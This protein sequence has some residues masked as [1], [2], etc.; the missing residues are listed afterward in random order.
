MKGVGKTP[1]KTQLDPTSGPQATNGAKKTAASSKGAQKDQ[2]GAGAVRAGG[3]AASAP[4]PAGD[5]VA[6]EAARFAEVAKIPAR[7]APPSGAQAALMNKAL[8]ATISS[9][10]GRMGAPQNN[11]EARTRALLYVAHDAIAKHGAIVDGTAETLT[12]KAPSEVAEI[13]NLSRA[14][15]GTLSERLFATFDRGTLL[16][17]LPE[18]LTLLLVPTNEAQASALA[19]QARIEAERHELSDL[20]RAIDA[21]AGAGLELDMGDS[22]L[23]AAAQ[24][25]LAL[26]PGPAIEKLMPVFERARTHL[27]TLDAKR[28]AMEEVRSGGKGAAAEPSA[29]VIAA[30][31]DANMQKA[32]ARLAE[33]RDSVKGAPTP[34]MLER[35]E[36]AMMGTAVADC[37]G[38]T[39]EFM[40]REDIRFQYGMN[41]DLIGG[42]AFEWTP[43]EPTDDTQMALAMARSIVKKGGFDRD[44]VSKHFVGWYDTEPKDI[45]GLTRN[46]LAHI[47]H[48]VDPEVAGFAPW[49]F[50][51]FDNA[52]NGSVMRA[53]PVALLTAFVD[54]AELIKTAHASSSMTHAD[55]RCTWGTAAMCKGMQLVLAGEENVTAKVATWLEDKNPSLAAALKEVPKLAP[56]DV[57]TTGFVVDTV[58]AA[59]YALERFDNYVDAAAF[60]TNHGEDT[61]TAGATG[62]MLL[63]AKFGVKAI[64]E[65]WAKVVIGREELQSLAQHIHGLASV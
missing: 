30:T 51:G 22:M 26:E 65:D 25:A 5:K 28:L 8:D 63:G 36:G 17:T 29:E 61:D 4:M 1:P 45:G 53:V 44:D 58:Q 60:L 21:A 55:P 15:L 41:V 64:P 33:L 24:K 54:D 9:M 18:D 2:L 48:G 52:G 11:P 10:V 7:H 56:E 49:A 50:G 34:T 32:Q 20:L 62:G 47:K 59:F 40:A 23:I 19:I 6:L 46:T 37:L 13:Q 14:L 3:L 16:R 12:S 39:T 27:E 38:A 42:G 35:F 31:V 43:G 57:K